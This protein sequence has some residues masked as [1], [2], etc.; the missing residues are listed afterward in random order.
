MPT[1]TGRMTATT[2]KYMIQILR[3]LGSVS[4]YGKECVAMIK[5]KGF[6]MGTL[7]GSPT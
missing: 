2:R 4:W 7:S 6:A 3:T 5:V 1:V